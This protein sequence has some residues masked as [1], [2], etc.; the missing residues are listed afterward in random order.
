MKPAT[1]ALF[2][3]G[4]HPGAW[5]GRDEVT[6]NRPSEETTSE[7]QSSVGGPM[8]ACVHFV[9]ATADTIDKRL[10][11]ISVNSPSASPF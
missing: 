4:G 1:R 3:Q 8:A 11:K 7:L 5:I 2:G 10:L 9:T 6:F